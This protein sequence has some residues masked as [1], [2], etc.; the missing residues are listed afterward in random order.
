[1]RS[2]LE[3]KG[4]D[5]EE[6]RNPEGPSYFERLRAVADL[7]YDDSVEKAA[8][9]T[10]MEKIAE[11]EGL[12]AQYEQTNGFRSQTVRDAVGEWAQAFRSDLART[13]DDFAQAHVVVVQ[14]RRIM[15]QARDLFV[16]NV[17]PE[18]LTDGEQVF[19]RIVST[20]ADVAA[21]VVPIGGYLAHVA[22]DTFFDALKGQREDEREAYCKQILDQMNEKLL[23][24]SGVIE[25]VE[26]GQCCGGGDPL[27][28]TA[29]RQGV[30]ADAPGSKWGS[31][32]FRRPGLPQESPQRV[33]VKDLEGVCLLERPVNQSVTPNG[34]VDGYAP[35]S[36]TD[37]SD[38]R[39]DKSYRIPSSIS[40]VSRTASMGAFGAGGAKAAQ[41]LS[42]R[43]LLTAPTVGGDFRGA[44]TAPTMVGGGVGIPGAA[45]GKESGKGEKEEYTFSGFPGLFSVPTEEPTAFKPGPAHG[46]GSAD[47]GTE[48]EFRLEDWELP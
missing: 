10:V 46:P 28:G 5:V 22:V 36:A 1:M 4:R 34:L 12:V 7:R 19:E 32:G 25:D 20:G 3:W 48:F 11:C 21:V 43:N 24:G 39:W 23:E 2:S 38:P 45:G 42:A 27:D 47:D 26:A 14:A 33:P 29:R 18:L 8:Y 15:R 41:A 40:D 13:R 37:F 16:Q 9:Q 30:C 17:S 35:P 44:A 6:S 31:E